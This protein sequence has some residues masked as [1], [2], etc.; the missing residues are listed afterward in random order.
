MLAL[1]EGHDQLAPQHAARLSLPLF[2]GALYSAIAKAR[3]G[4]YL[5]QPRVAADYR[6]DNGGMQW[7]SY[8]LETITHILADPG[9]RRVDGGADWSN[10][11]S[12]HSP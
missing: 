10:D 9:D 8:R 7:D 1:L 5:C 4:A 3:A 2:R 11:N 12:R 6:T